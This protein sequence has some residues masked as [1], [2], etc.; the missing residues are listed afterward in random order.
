MGRYVLSTPLMLCILGNRVTRA[1][2]R[3]KTRD[4]S[5]FTSQLQVTCSI[6]TVARV[7]DLLVNI[8]LLLE[9]LGS[10]C[11]EVLQTGTRIILVDI[12][13]LLLGL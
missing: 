9:F 7:F 2:G 1:T 13:Q 8:T 6:S 12:V 5:I 11:D 10:A 3:L 4:V